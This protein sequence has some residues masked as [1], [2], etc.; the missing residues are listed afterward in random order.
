MPACLPAGFCFVQKS[1]PLSPHTVI[2]NFGSVFFEDVYDGR[3]GQ[4]VRAR[5]VPECVF[6]LFFSPLCGE[7]FF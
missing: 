2:A 1:F 6:S 4:E 3:G 5:D 7:P